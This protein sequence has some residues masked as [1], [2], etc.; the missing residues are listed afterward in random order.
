M[1]VLLFCL[2]LSNK[3]LLRII[4]ACP[5]L[6]IGGTLPLERGNG[7]FDLG[8]DEGCDMGLFLTKLS[9]GFHPDPS[10]FELDTIKNFYTST[11][12]I[13]WLWFKQFCFWYS[14]SMSLTT[15]TVKTLL[16]NLLLWMIRFEASF[17][18]SSIFYNTQI[19]VLHFFFLRFFVF[20]Q[21]EILVRNYIKF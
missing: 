7:P 14:I 1:L 21:F 6:N 9:M 8:L 3:F 5:L 10:I 18:S 15:D 2:H 19:S 11:T 4:V 13:L 12:N 16:I 20:S 17:G